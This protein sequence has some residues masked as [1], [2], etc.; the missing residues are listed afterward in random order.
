MQQLTREEILNLNRALYKAAKHKQLIFNDKIFRSFKK[1]NTDFQVNRR[2][3]GINEKYGGT[4]MA[5]FY[6]GLSL[7]NVSKGLRGSMRTDGGNSDATAGQNAETRLKQDN[8]FKVNPIVQKTNALLQII[9]GDIPQNT[10]TEI[11]EKT[12]EALVDSKDAYWYLK[13]L[14]CTSVKLNSYLDTLGSVM[15]SNVS[16]SLKKTYFRE[17]ILNL[18]DKDVQTAEKMLTA[19][20]KS[21]LSDVVCPKAISAVINKQRTAQDI[22]RILRACNID[23]LVEHVSTSDVKAPIKCYVFLQKMLLK[24]GNYEAAALMAKN[25]MVAPLLDGLLAHNLSDTFTLLI[26]SKLQSN[27]LVQSRFFRQ[28]LKQSDDE[29]PLVERRIC[30]YLVRFRSAGCPLDYSVYDMLI[31]W[32]VKNKNAVL[33]K[34]VSEF[35]QNDLC[36]LN[37]VALL[38]YAQHLNR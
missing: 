7:L 19:V 37:K 10:I 25:H 17:V 33:F 13:I 8:R 26:R 2:N 4:K 16:E 15:R 34:R 30:N 1:G 3:M 28:L 24:E 9:R 31:K 5:M 29:E 14:A 11:H 12:L 27:S 36:E 38:D 6:Q 21:P 35:M 18:C 32:S 20:K 23:T 22:L